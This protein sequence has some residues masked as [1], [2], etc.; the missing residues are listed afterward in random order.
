MMKPLRWNSKLD[1]EEFVARANVSAF[2]KEFTFSE[3]AFSPRPGAALELADNLV[4]LGD[5]AIAMQ[6][7]QRDSPTTDAN[8]EERWFQS[9]V[10]GK[11]T[12]QIRDTLRYLDENIEIKIRNERGHEFAV[13]R[14]ELNEIVKVVVF[15]ADKA[16]PDRCWEKQFHLSKTVGYIHII[17]ANDYLGILETLSVPEDIRRYFEYREAVTQQ[18]AEIEKSVGEQD[19]M[20][21]FLAEEDIPT[22]MSRNTLNRLTQNFDEFD[23][24]GIIGSLHDHIERAENPYDYYQIM[25]EFARVP[26]SIWQAF[27]ERFLRSLDAVKN[28]AFEQP[29]RFYFPATDCA[30]MIMPLDPRIDA[31]GE[32]GEQ[33]RIKGLTNLTHAAKYD[34]QASKGVGVLISK[35]GEYFMVDWTLIESEWEPDAEMDAWLKAGNPFRP[36]REQKIDSFQIWN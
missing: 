14:S 10:L 35:D 27:K 33:N 16:L 34:A 26:R 1:L 18:L 13:R 7:K 28:E 3:N 32:Q 17:A 8:S 11:A 20:G 15:L 4:W 23:I 12:R 25:L 30:F 9:K 21:A 5:Y 24:S 31:V 22:K 2:W 36:A 19:I 6:L 29:F